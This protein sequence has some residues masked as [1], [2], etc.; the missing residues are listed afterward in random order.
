MILRAAGIKNSRVSDISRFFM[1][2]SVWFSATTLWAGSKVVPST[3][4]ISPRIAVLDPI[5]LLD[6]QPKGDAGT[7][8]RTALPGSEW[9]LLSHDSTSR[10][11]REYGQNPD[12]A[13][14][15]TQC[16]FDIGNILQ[17]D[18][19]LYGTCS[20]FGRIDASTL[21]LLHI[22]TA[23][24]VWVRAFE[25]PSGYG[26]V[27]EQ[28][29]AAAYAK[30]IGDLKV[31]NLDLEKT[32]AKK[33]LAVVDLS[34]NPQSARVFFERVC[35]RIYGVRRYDLMA[36]SELSDLL[37][38]LD[39][40]KYSIVPSL[41]NMIG[42]G[43]KLGVGYLLYSRL[44]RDGKSHVYRLAFYDISAK[45]LV[46]ELPPQPSQD[47]SKLLDYERIFFKT[48]AERD[49]STDAPVAKVGAKKSHSTALW[50]SLGVLGVGGGLAAFWVESLGKGNGGKN[51]PISGVDEFGQ[52][53]NPPK[54]QDE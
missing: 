50:V 3:P 52:P 43:Q 9:T 7:V 45:K 41:E 53:L 38:A 46:L 33:S 30:E 27:R 48:L 23:Q 49:K 6:N 4:V 14:N 35:T 44:Y 47:D 19:V 15:S 10:K 54:K 39:I 2:F 32:L 28:N 37:N 29:L 36:P 26:V 21:K 5:D 34:D 25:S 40:N 8:L 51:D 16:A 20:N 31:S 13:C 11:L 22:P 1:V 18:Y 12:Q 24:I 42:L 17:V